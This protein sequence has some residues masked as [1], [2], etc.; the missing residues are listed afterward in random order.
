MLDTIPAP[1]T[2]TMKPLDEL[3]GHEEPDG[4]RHPDHPRADEWN[5]R[6]DTHHDTR[7]LLNSESEN[8][9]QQPSRKALEGRNQQPCRNAGIQICV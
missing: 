3:P 7:D 5:Q 9:E 8:R 2:T 6:Q 4:G 1:T